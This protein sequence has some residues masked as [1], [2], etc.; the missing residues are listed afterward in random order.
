MRAKLVGVVYLPR[1]CLSLLT[2]HGLRNPELEWLRG[3]SVTGTGL[4]WNQG[5]SW[6]VDTANQ[7]IKL[8]SDWLIKGIKLAPD[9]LTQS[10]KESS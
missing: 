4:Y 9:W 10:I 5:H 8:A 3:S 7:G 6:L 1:G 2:P